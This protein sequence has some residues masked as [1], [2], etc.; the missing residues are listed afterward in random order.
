M[1]E[2]IGPRVQAGSYLTLHYRIE[3]LDA[4]GQVSVF[5]D[6][7][8]DR[9]ATLQLGTGQWAD[10]METP[11]LGLQEGD[12]FEY[13]LSAEQAYGKRHPDLVQKIAES[14][15]VQKDG[16]SDAFQPGEVVELVTAQGQQYAGVV[17]QYEPGW[18]WVDFNHP[19]AGHDLRIE[20]YILGVL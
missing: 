12:Q 2:S 18:V 13:Q 17:R 7:F 15:L 4:R 8:A 19:L 11:L 9:P 1:S 10:Q 20:V 14:L 16:A 6:T 5:A 3:L